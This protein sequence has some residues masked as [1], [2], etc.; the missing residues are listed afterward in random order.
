MSFHMCLARVGCWIAM[1]FGGRMIAV[2]ADAE[3]PLATRAAPPVCDVIVSA[4]KQIR[5]ELVAVASQGTP[6]A[7]RVVA[8]SA[9]GE[10]LEAC[11]NRDG[12]FVIDS[13]TPGVWTFVAGRQVVTA[14]VW[15]ESAAPP[16][17]KRVLTF[18]ATPVDA[19]PVALRGQSPVGDF[20]G[21]N[22]FLLGATIA[23]AI[24]IPIAIHH[25]SS[26]DTPSG[27]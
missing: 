15:T 27:S 12:R 17:A 18:G 24:A 5:G 19:Q 14:R 22:R 26:S 6:V 4:E 21:S 13:I 8:F 7:T 10:T 2:S 3:E 16:I 1:L 11:S 23:G 25:G 9:S 20:F